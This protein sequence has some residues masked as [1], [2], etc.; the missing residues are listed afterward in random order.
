MTNKLGLRQDERIHVFRALFFVITI[1]CFVGM[2]SGQTSS[3]DGATPLRLTPGSPSGSYALSDLD[4][5]NLYNGNLSFHL[6]LLA[7]GGRGDAGYTMTV[8]IESHWR[9]LDRSND[10]Q[11]IFLPTDQP[12][13]GINPN[14]GPAVL[15]GRAAAASF[16]NGAPCGFPNTSYQSLTRLTFILADGTEYEFRDQGTGGQQKVSSCSGNGFNRGTVF[17]AADGSAATFV[18]D[19]PIYDTP[20]TYET[21]PSGY[22]MLRNGLKYR[23]DNG[24]LSWMRDRNG[25]KVSFSYSAGGLS[26]TDSLNRQITIT[27]ADFHTTFYDLI[28]FK[29]FGGAQRSIQVNH[30]QL[31]DVL[32]T[33]RPGDIS[34]V[35]S[36]GALFP[37]LNGSVSTPY[38]P[39]KISSVVLPDTRQYQFRY[40]VY[41]ELARVMLPTGGMFEYDFVGA[42]PDGHPDGVYGEADIY[43]RVSEKRIYRDANNQESKTLFASTASYSSPSSV[44]VDQLDPSGTVLLSRVRHYFNASPIAGNNVG[45]SPFDYPVWTDGKEYQTEIIDT[46]NCTPATCSTVLR[47]TTQV[48]QQG[49]TVSSWSSAIANNPRVVETDLTLADTNQVAKQT[50]GYDCFNNRTDVYE[51]D[52]GAT[53]PAR[54]SHTDYVTTASYADWSGAHLRSLPLQTAVFD[55]NEFERARSTFEYDNYVRD[56]ACIAGQACLHEALVPRSGISGECDGSS[57]NCPNGPDFTSTSYASRG[58]VTMTTRYLLDPN[59][60]HLVLG[61]I[62]AYAQYDIAGNVVKTID[63]RSTPANVIATTFDYTDRF[64]APDGEATGNSAP[65]ELSSAGQASYAFPTLIT[66]AAGQTFFSQLDYYLGRPVNTQD[67]NGVVS[68]G[69]YSDS[70][71]RP[72]QTIRAINDNSTPSTKS[73]TTF[74]YDD[75]NHVVTLTSDQTSYGDNVLKGQAIYDGLGRTTE[76]RQY[77]GASNYIAVQTQYDGLARAYKTSNPFRPW[78]SESAIWTITGFDALGRVISVTTPDSALVSTSYL[79][80]TVTVTDQAGKQRKRVTDGL[81]RLTQVYEAPNDQNYNYLTSYDYD[82]LGNL[83]HVYQGSQTRTF[84]YDSLSRLLSAV[85][86]ESGTVNY[87]YDENGNL[88][89]KTDARLIT[90]NYV[91]DALNRV[92]SRS[93]QNDPNN[94]PAV[95]YN[96]DPN[97]A[98]GKG[99]LGSVV[100]SVS[101]YSYTNYDALGRVKNAGQTIGAQTYGMSYSY[102]LAGQVLSM[103]YPSSH[104]V[105]YNYDNAGRLADRDATHLAFTGNL[106]D[107]GAIKNYSSG[108]SYTPL[109]GMS[110]E[111]FGTATPI[112]NKLFYNSRGQLAE[113]REGITP[114]D[115]N[116]E[117]GAIINHYSNNCWGMCSGSSMPDNNGDLQKQDVYI[118]GVGTPFSQFYGYDSLDRLQSVREDN[119]NGSANWKQ[120]YVYDRYGNRTVDQNSA[121]TYGN[122]IPKPYFAVDT[123]TSNNRL[124]VPTGQ[125]GTMHYD[126]AGNLDIDTYSAAAVSRL[127]DAE[128]R[129]TKETQA[130]SY[131]AGEYFYDGDGH[132][133]KRRA[134]GAET[135]QIY[136]IGGELIA[137]YA[138]SGALQKE[139]GYRNGQLLVTATVNTGGWGAPPAFQD[140][141]LVVGQTT[142]RSVHITELRTAIDAVRSH[143]NLGNYPW[144]APAAPGDPVSIAPIQ[145][146]RTALDQALGAGSYAGGLASGQ[147]ILKVHIQELRDRILAVWQSGGGGV[148]IRWLVADQL[149]TPRIIFDQSGSLAT[150]SRHDYLPFGEE[151]TTQGGRTPQLGYVGDSTRQKFTQKERDNETG[152][153]YFGARDYASIQGRFTSADPMLSSGSIQS[154]Q[155]WNRYSYTTNNPL[156]YVDPLGLFKWG[157]SLG[158]DASDDDL[159]QER[160]SLQRSCYRD[161]EQEAR[162][163]EISDILANRQAFRDALAELD[164]AANDESLSQSQR[165]E[166][167]RSR[168]AY[169]SEGSDNGVSVGSGALKNNEGAIT[170]PTGYMRDKNNN[171]VG[172]RV[173]VTIGNHV[174]GQ[175]LVMAVGHEGS[176]VADRQDAVAVWSATGNYNLA[177]SGSAT[178]YATEDRAYHVSA[179][180]AQYQN[181]HDL[182]FAGGFTIWKRGMTNVD[183][184]ALDG[185]LQSHYHVTPTSQGD[186]LL[187]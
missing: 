158:G 31:H 102:D 106:G 159:R 50:F 162:I 55:A 140:N 178:T 29:G 85:N 138:S 63:A 58:N 56:A 98:N 150:T 81:G 24:S 180:I 170:T 141:P 19:S 6:P 112:Y 131:V 186:R 14:Y 137:E 130:N 88:T 160:D 99:R 126:A 166:I 74:A 90:T 82:V 157:R 136:D 175:E 22:V 46:A 49:C 59:T 7:V 100:S 143:S 17:V 185:L 120:S 113:I 107:G 127:Y 86:P 77:E 179:A 53:S 28:T 154:P 135:W 27:Y 76:K 52:Y 60:N 80:N 117:R 142:I 66:N 69:S 9:V 174:S 35:Q 1:L 8:P 39:Y 34:T 75:T 16:G 30:S 15:T 33:D 164:D 125:S 68:A 83:G 161:E 182:T 87:A 2:A 42:S 26:I 119:V 105:N 62:S 5:V 92:I 47:R 10:N 79:G 147:P 84:S 44:I 169:G 20:G 73:Q 165:D 145:E 115:T 148:D 172:A 38:D 41:G 18:A 36:K 71:D 3:T 64:G 123:T 89:S 152:L 163:D 54:H 181:R 116:W 128:N 133:V 104:I 149:G 43:R 45:V 151:L 78:Q 48:W 11:E 67:P 97:I 124:I 121:N 146:M 93:Y 144:A 177:R 23:I 51:Y 132:R 183:Q 134:G 139:Y 37:E 167:Q 72:T 70:L 118:P 32:R 94:T 156:K 173:E 108:I 110:Q 114:N 25:N 12:W 101:T 111:Q 91:Y 109:G 61:S 57:L 40:N 129:M 171:V 153:D 122:G 168:N 4:T 176:H 95:T 155:T 21:F 96:Y 184:H 13:N 103:T 65:I 187:P